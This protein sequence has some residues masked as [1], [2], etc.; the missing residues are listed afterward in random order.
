MSLLSEIHPLKNSPSSGLFVINLGVYTNERGTG[1]GRVVLMEGASERIGK[2]PGCTHKCSVIWSGRFPPQITERHSLAGCCCSLKLWRS[3]PLNPRCWWAGGGAEEKTEESRSVA[4]AWG[5]SLQ[6]WTEEESAPGRLALERR[7]GEEK[8]IAAAAAAAFFLSLR[9]K[10]AFSSPK[11]TCT[12]GE[13]SLY[14]CGSSSRPITREDYVSWSEPVRDFL[15]V[16]KEP[17][18]HENKTSWSQPG[19]RLV[20]TGPESLGTPSRGCGK[21]F[22]LPPPQLPPPPHHLTLKVKS[23]FVSPFLYLRPWL[24]NSNLPSLVWE[25]MF[26]FN[27]GN[28]SLKFSGKV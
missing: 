7:W 16:L 8:R 17:R 28:S 6:D 12:V 2:L 10:K 15:W 26:Q 18:Q 3:D 19:C 23:F 22:L 1:Q 5:K 20:L 27:V 11:P 24:G 9:S 13:P 14:F 4:F 25:E 21:S